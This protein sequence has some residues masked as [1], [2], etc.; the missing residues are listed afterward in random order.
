MAAARGWC[1]R[2]VPQSKKK[3]KQVLSLAEFNSAPKPG[4]SSGGGYRAPSARA[5][6]DAALVL[7]TGP[8]AREGGDDDGARPGLGGAFKDYG[9]ERDGGRY[10][11]RGRGVE[12]RLGSNTRRP[13]CRAP[14]APPHGVASRGA[15][16]LTR[17]RAA[18]PSGARGWGARGGA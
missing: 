2:A 13:A 9:P 14:R 4:A 16:V 17:V 12:S 3:T 7:P 8:R 18:S 15:S 5:P 1:S 10:G 11:A 6:D